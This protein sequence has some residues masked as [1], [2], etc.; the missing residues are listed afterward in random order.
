MKK[1]KEKKALKM[2]SQLVIFRGFFSFFSPLTLNLIFF[3]VN[4]LIKRIWPK[5]IHRLQ[6]QLRRIKRNEEKDKHAPPSSS[7]KKK[8]ESAIIKVRVR[9]YSFLANGD[10]S[11]GIFCPS[12]GAEFRPHSQSKIATFFPN[13]MSVFPIKKSKKIYKKKKK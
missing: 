3:P 12:L 5:Y 10:L 7:K 1:M 4:Q 13:T 8:K 6:E 9:L 2:T 11:E